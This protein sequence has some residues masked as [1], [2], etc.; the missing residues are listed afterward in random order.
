LVLNTTFCGDWAGPEFVGPTGR[1]VDACRKYVKGYP[2]E[3][4]NAYWDINYI[5]A[6]QAQ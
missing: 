1:G 3:F 2:N 5:R 6:Y 4:K